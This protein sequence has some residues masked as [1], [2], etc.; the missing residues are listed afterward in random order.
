MQTLGLV[1][2]GI[3]FVVFAYIIFYL[4]LFNYEGLAYV[5]LGFLFP[6]VALTVTDKYMK[7]IK[8]KS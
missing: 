7:M 2:A 8:R 1:L 3:Y 4:A 6:L 5:G